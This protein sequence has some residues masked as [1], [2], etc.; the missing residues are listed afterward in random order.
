M[1]HYISRPKRTRAFRLKSDQA[2][3]ISLTQAIPETWKYMNGSVLA[4]SSLIA[5]GK[6]AEGVGYRLGRNYGNRPTFMAYGREGQ[7]R[8][9]QYE[10]EREAFVN[11]VI[12][13]KKPAFVEFVEAGW[14]KNEFSL[15]FCRN[16]MIAYIE[17]GYIPRFKVTSSH[18]DDDYGSWRETYALHSADWQ[19]ESHKK[20]LHAER[21]CVLLE[22]NEKNRGSESTLEPIIAVCRDLG[23]EEF[24]LG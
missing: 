2:T 17:R 16:A 15:E 5:S 14:N 8:P 19:W 12:N 22:W 6:A 13:Q 21:P 23:L 18:N 1:R 10:A 7:K 24:K 9:D 20:P 11:L 3:L 4:P